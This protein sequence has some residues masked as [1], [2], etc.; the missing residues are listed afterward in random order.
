[1]ISINH[2]CALR[3]IGRYL[4]SFEILKSID[5]SHVSKP[6]ANKFVYYNNLADTCYLIGEIE[7]AIESHKKA[8][9]AYS[10]LPDKAKVSLPDNVFVNL[11]AQKEF[12]RGNYQAVLDIL[13]PANE[14]KLVHKID[15]AVL[16]AKAHVALGHFDDARRELS[17][18]I[19]SGNKLYAV[20]EAKRILNEIEGK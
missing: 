6:P 2:A 13:A 15:N 20:I 9:E 5:P 4:Q 16:R 18:V 14:K 11:D 8:K 12:S 7:E 19:E 3:N 17:F 10:S 1:M